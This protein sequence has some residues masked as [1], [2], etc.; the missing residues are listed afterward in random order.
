VAGEQAF[1]DGYRKIP[2]KRIVHVHAKDC[3]VENHKPTWGPL[4]QMGVIDWKGQIRALAEDGYN[5][6]ISLETHW[7]GPGGNKH[8]ASMICG[9]NLKTLVTAS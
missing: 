7:P 8:E 2:I 4:G 5:G 6:Y 3:V 9:R 1:P